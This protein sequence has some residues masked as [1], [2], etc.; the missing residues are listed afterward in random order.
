MSQSDNTKVGGY[1]PAPANMHQISTNFSKNIA[2]R[3]ITIDKMKKSGEEV[4]RNK[5]MVEYSEAP[6]VPQYPQS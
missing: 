4:S 6:Y 3:H 1:T 2:G 5:I